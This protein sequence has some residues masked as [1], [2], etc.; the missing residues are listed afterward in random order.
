[1]KKLLLFLFLPFSLFS[2]KHDN[3]WLFGYN[4][5][6][7]FEGAEGII[8]NF[9]DEEPSFDYIPMLYDFNNGSTIISDKEGELSFYFNGC[10]VFNAVHEI[11]E[12]GNGLNPGEV[13]DEK[14]PERYT[15]GSQSSLILPMPN[16]DSIYYVIR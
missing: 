7:F 3:V 4:S 6:G 10:V 11:M 16:N 8:R 9:S 12:N 14:C 13:S 1:M 15:S 5:S 2:Q